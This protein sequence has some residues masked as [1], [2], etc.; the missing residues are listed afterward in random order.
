MII[1]LDTTGNQLTTTNLIPTKTGYTG[2]HAAEIHF[3]PTDT[4]MSQSQ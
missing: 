2:W 1:R 4:K 3:N